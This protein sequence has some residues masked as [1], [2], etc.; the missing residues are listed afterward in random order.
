MSQSQGREIFIQLRKI[1]RNNELYIDVKQTLADLFKYQD[2]F[3]N[4]RQS[5]LLAILTI[6]TVVSGIFG[7]NQ[8]IED[9]KGP[10]DFSKI[11]DYSV[12]EYIAMFTTFSGLFIAFLLGFGF[13]LKWIKDKKNDP[14]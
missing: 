1:F 4:K 10:M 12:F 13:L 14:V 11:K 6:Y 2:A 3:S 9:L 8:V 7:M 5:Y